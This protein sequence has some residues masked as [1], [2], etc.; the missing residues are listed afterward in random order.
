MAPSIAVYANEMTLCVTHC[1]GKRLARGGENTAPG[2][3]T[4][5]ASGIQGG[6]VVHLDCNDG[7]LTAELLV[8]DS[9]LVQGLDRDRN[10]VAAARKHLQA[11]CVYGPVSVDT[12]DGRTLPDADNLVN[13]VVAEQTRVPRAEIMRGLPLVPPPA[14]PRFLQ[15]AQT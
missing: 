15:E 14:I 5:S 9:Y 4:G 3:R 1:Q 8:N 6:L 7:V 2:M 10:D 11:A 12:F 13:L